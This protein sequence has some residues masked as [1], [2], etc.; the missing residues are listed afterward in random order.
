M[1]HA[2]TTHLGWGMA[3]AVL[4]IMGN[5][6]VA[7]YKRRVGHRI[8]SRTLL[9]DA[10]HSWLDAMSSLG[11]LLGLVAVALGFRL[12]DPIA[13]FAITLF[14]LRVGYEVTRDVLFHLMDGVEVDRLDQARDTAEEAT[15]LRVPIVRGRW[16]GRSLALELEPVFPYGTSLAEANRTSQSM[17][18]AVMAALDEVAAVTVV[19]HVALDGAPGSTTN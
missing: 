6:A 13:G 11:A 10:K 14:I 19:P 4:G 18:E 2:P 9:A 12:G 1:S 3:R 5:Q 15:Q 7:W 17:T 16:L 8:G